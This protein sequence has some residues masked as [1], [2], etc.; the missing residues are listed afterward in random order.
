MLAPF[1]IEVPRPESLCVVGPNGGGKSTFLRLML[2]LLKPDTGSI[3]IRGEEPAAVRSRMGYVP[4]AGQWDPLFPI[5]VREVVRMGTLR[6]R[7]WHWSSRSGGDR[8]EAVL[9]ELGLRHLRDRPFAELSGGERQRVLIARALAGDPEILLLDEPMA[10][11]DRSAEDGFFRQLTVLR[12]NLPVILVTHHLQ[13]VPGMVERVL[14][15]N[16]TV[17]LHQTSSP[18]PGEWRHWVDRGL[19]VVRHQGCETVP[20]ASS[21]EDHGSTE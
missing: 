16:R 2:G 12:R 9:E 5:R 15:V 7:A 4:Q 13:L 3:R 1:S 18:E 6:R 11:V 19:R 10:H 17:H 8:V 20:A 21:G 14:C